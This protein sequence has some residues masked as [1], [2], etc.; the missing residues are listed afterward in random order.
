MSQPLHY[1]L[2]CHHPYLKGADMYVDFFLLL[3]N[4][5]V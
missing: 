5:D 3:S 4:N 1:F 2:R